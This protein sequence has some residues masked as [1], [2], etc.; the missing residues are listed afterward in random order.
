MTDVAE[1]P[2]WESFCAFHLKNPWVYSELVSM[3][4]D[5][6]DRGHDTVGMG[7]LFEVLRWGSMMK[8]EDESGL[9]LPN[10]YR[11]LYARMIMELEPELDGV[12]NL[13]RLTSIEKEMT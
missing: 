7:M 5:L 9:K 1:H 3:T 11:S 8:T 13:S 2:Y 6:V 10:S 4:R 12:F